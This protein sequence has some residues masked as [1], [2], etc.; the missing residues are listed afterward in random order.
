MPTTGAEAFRGRAFLPFQVD[1]YKLLRSHFPS[2][3]SCTARQF[4][5]HK[6]Q[7]LVFNRWPDFLEDDKK[8]L[9]S[10]IVTLK[11]SS[12]TKDAILS[13]FFRTT[14]ISV[15]KGAESCFS[16]LRATVQLRSMTT[17]VA[18]GKVNFAED[19]T[20]SSFKRQD[21][22][23]LQ[24]PHSEECVCRRAAPFSKVLAKTTRFANWCEI[25]QEG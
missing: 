10:S 24:L 11:L 8:L 1:A 14:K 12:C 5:D 13:G 18:T 9:A 21:R 23:V 15:G 20:I 4:R 17:K 19:S 2:M 16:S 25:A 6:P 3:T 22:P 7:L